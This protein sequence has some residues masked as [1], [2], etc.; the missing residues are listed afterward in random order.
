MDN[1]CLFASKSE[2]SAAFPPPPQTHIAHRHPKNNGKSITAP[3]T[4][5]QLPSPHQAFRIPKKK[6]R[7]YPVHH[8]RKSACKLFWQSHIDKKYIYIHYFLIFIHRKSEVCWL[9]SWIYTYWIAYEYMPFPFPSVRP[10]PIIEITICMGESF[11][12]NYISDIRY[13][14]LKLVF[15]RLWIMRCALVWT[16]PNT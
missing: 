9:L 12:V 16:F 5:L 8:F 4:R 15:S 6:P 11:F 2:L 10:S 1:A 14:M 7:K 3:Q 13:S